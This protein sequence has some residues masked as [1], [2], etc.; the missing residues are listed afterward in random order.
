MVTPLRPAV[1]SASN[2]PTGPWIEISSSL[3]RSTAGGVGRG[4]VCCSAGANSSSLRAS[5]EPSSAWSMIATSFTPRTVRSNWKPLSSNF[6]VQ[7]R[8]V[9]SASASMR[10]A[11]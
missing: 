5:A 3:R 7:P 1:V 8:S 6:P 9:S 10:L 4:K 11:M 2:R